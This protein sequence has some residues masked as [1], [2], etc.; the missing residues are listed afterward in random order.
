MVR[1][2]CHSRLRVLIARLREGFWELCSVQVVEQRM[3][4]GQLGHWKSCQEGVEWVGY[5]IPWTLKIVDL[6]THRCL[7]SSK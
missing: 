7:T 5:R 2:E 1:N 6:L 3:P 4:V